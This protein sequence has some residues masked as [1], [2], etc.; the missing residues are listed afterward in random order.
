MI[1]TRTSAVPVELDS[2]TDRYD[3]QRQ[4][5]VVVAVIDSTGIT[6]Q[7]AVGQVYLPRSL[8]ER[9]HGLRWIPGDGCLE[10]CA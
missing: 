10:W 6:G 2:E 7:R 9:N 3:H 5:H 4:G 8:F 1:S